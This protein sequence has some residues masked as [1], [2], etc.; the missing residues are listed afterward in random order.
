M[1]NLKVAGPHWILR[2]Y[3][4]K[5]RLF[6]LHLHGKRRQHVLAT[7][8]GVFRIEQLTGCDVFA[9]QMRILKVAPHD[10]REREKQLC[11]LY[12]VSVYN[13]FLGPRQIKVTPHINYY[14]KN[15]SQKK[16]HTK[17]AISEIAKTF[18]FPITPA[19]C[20][21]KNVC[22]KGAQKF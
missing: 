2:Y 14:T 16:T 5:C 11:N 7:L 13:R 4:R 21:E 18:C 15:V 17:L 9:L 8:G 3:R 20:S 1:H 22:S 12:T 10:F 6:N 19:I